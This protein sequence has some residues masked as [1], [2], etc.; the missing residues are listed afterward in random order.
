MI[1]TRPGTP[2]SVVEPAAAPAVADALASR[3]LTAHFSGS[4][5][6]Y[7]RIWLLH[8]LLIVLTLGLYLPFAKAR[9]IRYLYANSWIHGDALAFHGDPKTMFRASC[10]GQDQLPT[11]LPIAFS[12]HP[13][14][15]ER[16]AFYKAEGASAP[17]N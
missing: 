8:L 14:D 15:A 13:G 7:L 5:F 3:E 9:R 4:G 10:P 16:I 1:P 6:E 12:S 2:P 11:P 17:K